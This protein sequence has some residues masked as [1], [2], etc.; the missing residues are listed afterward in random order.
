[1]EM[2]LEELSTEYRQ[3]GDLLRVRLRA[4]R[5][6]C[7]GSDDPDEIWHLQRRIAALAGMLRQVNDL[8]ELTARYYERGYSRSAYYT[9]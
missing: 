9:L 8:T 1:M 4:L 7:R 2:T 5:Q 6:A 3:S